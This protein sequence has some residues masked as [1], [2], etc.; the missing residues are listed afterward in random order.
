M[1][2]E[3]KNLEGDWQASTGVLAGQPLPD[4]IVSSTKLTIGT[5][6]YEVNLAGVI[7]RGTCLIDETARPITMRI[8]GTQGP[9]AGKTILAIVEFLAEDE[10]RIAYDLSGTQYPQTFAATDDPSNYVAALRRALDES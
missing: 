6:L 9:N 8:E 4:D 10:I 3:M 7:D 2:H 5:T 1:K